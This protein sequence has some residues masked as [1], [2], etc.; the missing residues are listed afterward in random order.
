MIKNMELSNF[1][2]LLLL[3]A[4]LASCSTPGTSQQENDYKKDNKVKGH[5][6]HGVAKMKENDYQGAFVE[7]KKVLDIN[8]NDKETLNAIGLVYHR[9]GDY[10]NAK[11][12]FL[13]AIAV[14]KN[15]SEAYNH[16]GITYAELGKWAE[17]VEAFRD[18]LKNPLYATPDKSYQ[19][20]G[21]SLYRIGK[22]DEAIRSFKDSIARTHT[23]IGSY[24]GIALCHNAAG[25][26]GE[27]NDALMEGIRLSPEYKGNVQ[28]AQKDFEK[29]R[30]T[31]TG[32]V[33]QDYANYLEI[34]NY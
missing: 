21:F 23:N 7:F 6:A 10:K 1:L 24:F 19:N 27:A 28:K 26:Y 30:R 12:S 29:K 34:L 9:F 20:L 31:S 15:Y 8:P 2:K 25:R 11:E 22:Y 14:D 16:L 17:S 33:E 5:Y 13:K 18:A 3:L 32:T 4:M